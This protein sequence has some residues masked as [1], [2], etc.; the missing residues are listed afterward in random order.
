MNARQSLSN[1]TRK[2]YSLCDAFALLTITLLTGASISFGGVNDFKVQRGVATVTGNG[3]ILNAPGA[4]TA[5]SNLSNAFVRITNSQHTGAGRDSGGGNQNA[6]DV[7]TSIAFINTGQIQLS[8]FGSANNTRV[9][10]EIVEYIG[11]AGGPNEIIVRQQGT[12]TFADSSATVQ[13]ATALPA[14]I[15]GPKLAGFVTGVANPDTG[16]ND[17]ETQLVTVDAFPAGP[18]PANTRPTFRRISDD[19]AV[20]VSYAVVEFRGGNWTV[21][22]AE[23][24]YTAAGAVETET[25]VPLPSVNNAFIHAQKRNASNLR[26]LDEHGHQVWLS[27]PDTV[28]FQ[29]RSSA[30]TPSGQTSVAWVV[31]NPQMNVFHGAGTIVAG[32]GDPDTTT[33]TYGPAAE[34]ANTSLFWNNDCSGGGRR[35]PRPMVSVRLTSTSQIEA[36]RSDSGEDQDYRFDVVEWPAI[37]ITGT[38]FTDEAQTVTIGAGKTVALSVNGAAPLTTMTNSAGAFCFSGFSS[39]PSGVILVYLDGEPETAS[40]VTVIGSGT[41]LQVSQS[42]ALI[43]ERIILQ[44][45]VGSSLTDVNLDSVDAVDAGNDDGITVTPGSV[46]FA[47]NREVWIE[48]GSTY[49]PTG[50]IVAG[51]VDIRGVL[52]ASSAGIIDVSGDWSLNGGIFAAG[53]T[54]V[55]F[56]GSG[57]AAIAG[58]STFHNLSCNVPGKTLQFAAGSNQTITGAFSVVG[59]AG[60][61]VKL[62]SASPGNTWAI[63]FSGGPQNIAEADVMD[64]VANTNIVNVTDGTNSGNNNAHWLFGPPFTVCFQD[65]IFPT[66]IYDG[67]R[68]TA[69]RGSDARNFGGLTF[70]GAGGAGPQLS[71]LMSWDLAAAGIPSGSA[72]NAAAITVSIPSDTSLGTYFLFELKPNWIEGTGTGAGGAQDGATWFEFAPGMPWQIPGASGTTTDRGTTVL[73]TS[74]VGGPTG[75]RVMTLNAAGVQ[76]VQD[77]LDGTKPNHG[78]VLQNYAAGN[79]RIVFSSREDATPALHPKLTFTYVTS[80]ATSD[81]SVTKTDGQAAAVPGAPITYTITVSNLGPDD[82]ASASVSD[83]FPAALTGVTY[84]SIASGG[85][86]GNTAGSGN[87]ADSLTLPNGSSVVYTVNATVASSAVGSLSNTASVSVPPSVTDPDLMNN[88]QTDIDTLTPV[89]DIVVSKTDGQTTVAAGSPLTYTITVSNAGPSDVAG[90]NVSDVFPAALTGVSWTSTAGGGATG[91]MPGPAGGS[92]ND[93]LNLPAGSSVVYTV[94][95]VVDSMATGNLVNTVTASVPGGVTDPATPNEDTDTNAI[96]DAVADLVITKDNGQVVAA[97]GSPI[98]TYTVQVTNNGPSSV[99]GVVV[100]D[101]FPGTLTGVSWMSTAAGGA[102]GNTPG[103]D[104]ADISDTLT[105]PAGSVVTYTISGNVDSNAAG[106]VIN[107]ATVAHTGSVVDP[108]E[109]NNSATDCDHIVIS[110][111][112]AEIENLGP[113]SFSVGSNRA[114]G[115]LSTFGVLGN[116]NN[117]ADLDNSE[118]RGAA[119]GNGGYAG[120]NM[121][122]VGAANTDVDVT[123]WTEF[124][125]D[126][127]GFNITG[128]LINSLTFEAELYL[129]GNDTNNPTPTNDPADFEG[130]N[131]A[132]VQIFDNA[133]GMWVDMGAPFLLR[134]GIDWEDPPQAPALGTV[135]GQI[136]DDTQDDNP[137]NHLIRSRFT[138]FTNDLLDGSGQVRIRVW[139][140]VVFVTDG[141]DASAAQFDDAHMIFDFARVDF[142]YGTNL[143]EAAY[144]WTDSEELSLENINHSARVAR[145]ELLHLRVAVRSNILASEGVRLGL[146]FAADNTFSSPA[147][148][149]DTTRIRYWDDTEHSE[150]DAVTD[151]LIPG[152]VSG[153]YHEDTVPSFQNFPANVLKEQDFAVQPVTA[154]TFFL[155]IVLVNS[156][157]EILGN[158]DAENQLIEL[159]VVDES[160]RQTGYD[161]APDNQGAVAVQNMFGN[162][163]SLGDNT[164]LVFTVGQV[165]MLAFQVANISGSTGNVDYQIQYQDITGGRVNSAWTSIQLGGGGGDW[166][167]VIA[168][169]TQSSTTNGAQFTVPAAIARAP[170]F[171]SGNGEYSDDGTATDSMGVNSFEERI[172]S[173]L[174]QAAAAD[175]SYKFRLRGLNTSGSSAVEIGGFTRSVFARAFQVTREQTTFRWSDADEAVLEDVDQGITAPNGTQLHLR[176]GMRSNNASWNGHFLALQ[177]DT[178]AN[179]ANADASPQSFIITPAS[180]NIRMWDDGDHG[181]SDPV[182]GAKHFTQDPEDGE[183]HESNVQAVAQNKTANSVYEEDFTVELNT[184]LAPGTIFHIRVVEVDSGGNFVGTLDTYGATANIEVGAPILRQNFYNWSANIAVPM[185]QGTD[186]ELELLVGTPYILAL[187]IENISASPSS[188]QWQLQYQRVNGTPGDWTDLD[189]SSADWQA[190]DGPFAGDQTP[191]PQATFVSNGGNPPSGSPGRVDGVYS[192]DGTP[193]LPL[194]AGDFTEFWLS[195]QPT[196]LAAGNKYR[197][198]LRNQNN[199]F[200]FIVYAIARET[201]SEQV[202]Y[203]WLDFQEGAVASENNAH[204][205][206]IAQPSQD[207]HLRVGVRM[208]NG[209]V[210]AVHL[211]VQF[212][213]DPNFNATPQLVPVSPGDLTFWDDADNIAADP[214]TS[215][216]LTG[217]PTAGVYHEGAAIQESFTADTLVEEDFAIRIDTGGTY[218]LRVVEITAAGAFICPLDIYTNIVILVGDTALITQ[219][220]YNWAP[221]SATPVFRGLNSALVFDAQEDFIL[222]IRIENVSASVTVDYDWQLQ[223]E[224]TTGLPGIWNDVT[225]VSDEWRAVDVSGIADGATVLQGDFVTGVNGN[226]NGRYAENG[227]H[228]PYPA[229]GPGQGTEFRFAIRALFPDTNGNHYRFRLTNSGSTATFNYTFPDAFEKTNDDDDDGLP[230]WWEEE[231]Y[232]DRD[233]TPGS[234]S[235]GDL[236]NSLDEY[237]MD[238]NPTNIGSPPVVYVD[239]NGSKNLGDGSLSFPYKY[240]DDAIAAAAATDAILVAPGRYTLEAQQ[241]TQN[242][243]LFA[244]DEEFASLTRAVNSDPRRTTIVGPI[245]SGAVG[246]AGQMLEVSAPRFLISGFTVRLYRDNAPV[247]S[248]DVGASRNIVVIR[249]MVF[250]DNT[251]DDWPVLQPTGVQSSPILYGYNNSFHGNSNNAAAGTDIFTAVFQGDP[252]FLAHNDVSDNIGDGVLVTGVGTGNIQNNV[253]RNN[254][255]GDASLA[256]QFR[257]DGALTATFAVNNNAGV[258]GDSQDETYFAGTHLPMPGSAGVN[259]GDRSFVPVDQRG[260]VRNLGGLPDRGPYEVDPLDGDGDGITDATEILTNPLLPDTDGDGLEDGEEVNGVT[261]QG[262]VFPPTDPV[263]ADSDGDMIGDMDE[264][265]F[266]TNPRDATDIDALPTTSTVSFE[267]ADW[268]PGQPVAAH[269]MI[270]LDNQAFGNPG[271]IVRDAISSPIT[272]HPV[273]SAAFEGQR[274]LEFRGDAGSGIFNESSVIVYGTPNVAGTFDVWITLAI[275]LPRSPLPT[276]FREAAHFGGAN[277]AI[278]ENG[279]LATGDGDLEKWIVNSTITI[280]DDWA[281]VAIHRRNQFDVDEKFDLYYSPDGNTWELMFANITIYPVIATPA[282]FIR[283]TFSSVNE[284]RTFFDI[285]IAHVFAPFPIADFDPAFDPGALPMPPILPVLLADS[286]RFTRTQT[287]SI[288]YSIDEVGGGNLEV[289]T[290][291]YVLLDQSED[292][293]LSASLGMVAS[294]A[295]LRVS[296][297]NPVNCGTSRVFT[298]DIVKP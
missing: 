129:T 225:T 190:V 163:P 162:P 198:R 77:W 26:G 135:E 54:T 119:D 258:T 287:A 288:D 48:S 3:L 12:V 199:A 167:S 41:S 56:S 207:L 21:A 220:G 247:I 274:C 164:P 7:T 168:S 265:A 43:T 23:H 201:V 218:Y 245:P 213:T 130:I 24:T 16:R 146:Q 71:G 82:M 254:R 222:A 209:D 96:V 107:T 31:A 156:L 13:P 93:T 100:S 38:V 256:V 145:N 89:A 173:I 297:E 211:G 9:A 183:Y 120:L 171:S 227:M 61:E 208:N 165:Y 272:G 140:D 132:R 14:G 63:T 29:L 109:T 143:E 144:L 202:S 178:T 166:V 251:T 244:T 186:D 191:V 259:S 141:N 123:L 124:V 215:V 64:A 18:L 193:T 17:Y 277:I 52:D 1:I 8:R 70:S 235:D 66:P 139:V 28:S 136:W 282:G 81:L 84:T 228:G 113:I 131:D 154:G 152:T 205:A 188:A 238:S 37:R 253:F 292:I 281:Q 239:D 111:P 243:F 50:G 284:Q 68:D 229:L 55:H 44:H 233:E 290:L 226:T 121:R 118:P 59:A 266:G 184:G 19:D 116:L 182:S 79:D 185:F 88:A 174:P 39:N 286:P 240:L 242:T 97:P 103:P 27:A 138:A 49:A 98:G 250:A 194:N 263:S 295:T 6:D 22:R 74:P 291:N 159:R 57:D 293:N 95:G 87:I 150:I 126:L 62:H 158:V 128:S 170:G 271:A 189:P 35:Y 69:I 223:F 106:N 196:P 83:V 5:V 34:L 102:T 36:W 160:F 47:P 224:R 73:G 219:Q 32:A 181:A 2:S 45:H 112:T 80:T 236:F 91:N 206:V 221:A 155:R 283:T 101:V 151:L 192:E 122:N 232:G 75:P 234:N 268:M 67:T 53:T 51:G 153:M 231:H 127:S 58:S 217:S 40:L 157:G 261:I 134:T 276:D 172:F 161:W 15:P 285:P 175:R 99:S 246:P 85:A 148:V 86:T 25:I 104:S 108:D 147:L 117:G 42:L 204:D 278:D 296:L 60:N 105:M 214:I 65:S 30:S 133:S 270:G 78:V 269:T 280:P 260:R 279:N 33:L 176:V 76:L 248:Y 200:V 90:S 179:F 180:T 149:A 115:Q 294:G 169:A 237:F 137:E 203:R 267:D 289:G 216:T 20:V 10:W 252:L 114:I 298:L 230:D 195:V 125:Y 197:F 249:N 210:P 46:T 212:D 264:V 262:V 187:Q 11:P 177:Y 255:K 275:Y 110:T 257:D 4:F 273:I 142:S 72:V 241:T 92:V 94:T